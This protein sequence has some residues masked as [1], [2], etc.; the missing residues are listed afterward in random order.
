MREDA[1]T[2]KKAPKRHLREQDFFC[3]CREI[4]ARAYVCAS[5]EVLDLEITHFEKQHF[6][7]GPIACGGD[8]VVQCG[9]SGLGGPLGLNDVWRIAFRRVKSRRGDGGSW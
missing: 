4:P 5:L 1:H 2:N 3:G 7:E 8:C 6:F 9:G